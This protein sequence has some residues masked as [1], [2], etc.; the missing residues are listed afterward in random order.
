[1]SQNTQSKEIF[2]KFVCF[3]YLDVANWMTKSPA[4][5]TALMDRCFEYD[6]ML[7]RNGHW[8]SG[9]ALAGPD[10]AATLRLRGGKLAVTDGP[11]AETK[12]LLGGLLLIEARD[13]KHATEL[14]GNH[15]GM[16]MGPWEI[17]ATEDISGIIAESEKRRRGKK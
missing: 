14:I 17:R 9:E 10:K 16:N 3:G 13:L 2:M 6:E 15:P 4:E 5:Q 12:E 7:K 11:Y 1:V 8:V